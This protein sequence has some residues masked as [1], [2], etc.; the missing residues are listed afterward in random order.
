MKVKLSHHVGLV[1]VHGFD[2]E[3]ET[4]GDLFQCEPVGKQ[5]QYLPF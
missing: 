3:K 1:R 4:R 5:F 2:A